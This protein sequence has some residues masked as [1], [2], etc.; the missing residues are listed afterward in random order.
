M[1]GVH[2]LSLPAASVLMPTMQLF[3]GWLSKVSVTTYLLTF[4]TAVL[5]SFLSLF[6]IFLMDHS[7]SAL[8]PELHPFRYI[9]FPRCMP[10]CSFLKLCLVSAGLV[11]TYSGGREIFLPGAILISTYIS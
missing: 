7:D 1:I 2:D 6:Q 3:R 11:T 8:L 5:A 9:P 10:L 4:K